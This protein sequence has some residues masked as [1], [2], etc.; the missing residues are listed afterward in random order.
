[1]AKRRFK[2]EADIA[3]FIKQGYGQGE[4]SSYKPWLRVQ[5]VPSLGRSRKAMGIKSGRTHHF[6][7]D[8]EYRYFL[9]LEFSDQVLDI[10]E[11]Y[12]LFVTSRSRDIAAQMGIQ[13]PVYRGT[14][15]LYVLTSDFVVTLKEPDG[16]KRLAIR[17]CKYER[18]LIDPNSG[19]WTIDKLDLERALWDDKSISDWK[20]V[21][22]QVVSQILFEN[23]D[24]LHKAALKDK[25]TLTP[26]LQRQFIG[27]LVRT[28]NGERTI[29]S[30]V[31]AASNAVGLT[32][33]AGI[34]LFK[35]L[36]WHKNILTDI[37]ETRLYQTLACP[38]LKA[39]V[40][41]QTTRRAA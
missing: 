9:L 27:F 17:T 25:T 3:R 32:Y 18:D 12:P 24:W 5:D 41:S 30:V 16:A 26:E 35:Q 6:L 31:R 14:Q 33:P 8:L 11:Q 2:T 21:T 38:K 28:A 40:I 37:V 36:L 4:G 39:P 29:S 19:M 23:L 34:T 10:R 22:E 15:L 20:I 7:S 13:Y 1:M